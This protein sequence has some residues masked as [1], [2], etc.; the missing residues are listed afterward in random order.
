MLI[1]Q[2]TDD[3][4]QAMIARDELK[5]TTLQGIK[6]TLKY[7]EI[8]GAEMDDAGVSKVLMKEA[9]KRKESIELY[10]KG[11]NQ[12]S[13]DKEKAEL[14]IIEAYLPEQ[15][16]EEEVAAAVDKAIAATGATSMQDMGKVIGMVKG[17][18]G[19]GVDGSVVAKLVKEKLA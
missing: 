16:S 19:D 15:A 13:A 10:E 5:K 3:L 11:G 1:D 18:L 8:D 7:A 17:E 2:I 12:E 4:K 6:A 14:E 9:K